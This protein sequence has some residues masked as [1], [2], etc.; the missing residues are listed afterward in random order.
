MGT[1]L[2]PGAIR[3]LPRIPFIRLGEVKN[4]RSYRRGLRQL[5][6]RDARG[7]T[8]LAVYDDDGNVRLQVFGAGK[9]PAAPKRLIY[10]RQIGRVAVPRD[11][12]GATI[13]PGTAPFGN[14]I[15][16]KIMDLIALVT[17]QR[18]RAKRANAP[19]P[20]LIAREVLREITLE[21]EGEALSPVVDRIVQTSRAYLRD[22]RNRSTGSAGERWQRTKAL[23]A[24]AARALAVLQGRGLIRYEIDVLLGVLYGLESVVRPVNSPDP[25]RR[26]R[27]VAAQRLGIART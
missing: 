22:W 4:V 17:G 6:S 15:E 21:L 11:A 27:H 3:T 23:G 10:N 16:P 18:F 1:S 25:L 26:F 2:K 12:V 7:N 13:K 8:A 14:A 5:A 24:L 20:D 19:G 9:L